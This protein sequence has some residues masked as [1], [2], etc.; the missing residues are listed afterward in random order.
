MMITGCSQNEQI[1]S[2]NSIYVTKEYSVEASAESSEIEDVVTEE[3]VEDVFVGFWLENVVN[4]YSSDNIK[5]EPIDKSAD[6]EAILFEKADRLRTL[7]YNY[8]NNDSENLIY[9]YDKDDIYVYQHNYK[10]GYKIISDEIKSYSDFKS[11][12]ADS[13]YG[14]YFDYINQHTYGRIFEVNGMLYAYQDNCGLVGTDETWY[15]GYDVYDDRIVGHYIQ[16]RGIGDP[17]EQ[18]AEYLNDENNYWFYDITV[19]LVNG[20]YVVTD[21]REITSGRNY[22]Y[23]NKH[24]ICYDSGF[25][26]R[27]LITNERLIP[28]Y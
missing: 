19:Q 5:C 25:A 7:I 8:L 16:L 14:D 27:S 6:C 12:F 4:D 15:M 10:L 17:S 1:S 20:V 9:E 3:A 2:S 24:G 22:H 13:I 11:L 28:K 26:D 23:F 18:T 21:C